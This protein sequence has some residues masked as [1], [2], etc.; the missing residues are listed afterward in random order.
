ML[1]QAAGA[2]I[3]DQLNMTLITKMRQPPASEFIRDTPKIKW[4][5]SLATVEEAER[6]RKSRQLEQEQLLL[7][8][9]EQH[10]NTSVNK[11]QEI[12]NLG[13]NIRTNEEEIMINSPD[14]GTSSVYDDCL[15]IQEE[16]QKLV[17]DDAPVAS[18]ATETRDDLSGISDEVPVQISEGV[19]PSISVRV[20]CAQE[21][22]LVDSV[23]SVVCN[24]PQTNETHIL[25]HPD[26]VSDTSENKTAQ[27]SVIVLTE[28]ETEPSSSGTENFGNEVHQSAI[29]Q[30]MSDEEVPVTEVGKTGLRTETSQNSICAKVIDENVSNDIAPKQWATS[31]STRALQRSPTKKVVGL[32]KSTHFLRYVVCCC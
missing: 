22:D 25:S 17:T 12:N 4:V 8:P 28:G 21:V 14:Y 24:E 2:K 3:K 19:W 16:K 11:A 7:P 20:S 10:E 26:T 9:D 30:K 18:A 29:E 13:T 1:L 31:N 5:S 23:D 32:Q 15:P 6:P 27:Q